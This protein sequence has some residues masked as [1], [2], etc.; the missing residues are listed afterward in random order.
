MVIGVQIYKEWMAILLNAWNNVAITKIEG[1]LLANSLMNQN[2]KWTWKKE[3]G[4][5]RDINIES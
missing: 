5:G 3:L 2:Y 1:S 4:I